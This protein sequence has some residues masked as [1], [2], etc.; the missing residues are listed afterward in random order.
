MFLL[1]KDWILTKSHSKLHYQIAYKIG[2]NR[3]EYILLDVLYEDTHYKKVNC[4]S[5]ENPFVKWDREKPWIRAWSDPFFAEVM[6]QA[7]RSQ[8][9]DGKILEQLEQQY[10]TDARVRVNAVTIAACWKEFLL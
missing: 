1:S 9:A 3:N 8:L 5:L 2:M 4:L 6:E 7:R 10:R